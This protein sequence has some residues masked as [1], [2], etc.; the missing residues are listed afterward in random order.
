LCLLVG[1]VQALDST[2]EKYFLL[3]CK[4]VFYVLGVTGEADE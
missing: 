4:Y 2:F 1:E 3:K